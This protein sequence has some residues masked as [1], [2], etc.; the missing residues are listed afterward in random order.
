MICPGII[1]EGHL[2][3]RIGK[4]NINTIRLKFTY[5]NMLKE[6]FKNLASISKGKVKNHYL[7][8]EA[9]YSTLANE[10]RQKLER[11]NKDGDKES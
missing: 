8:E 6:G 9:K 7:L 1:Q 3:R 11:I 5:F 2:A 10:M 4:M